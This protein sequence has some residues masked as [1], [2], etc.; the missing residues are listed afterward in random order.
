MQF[1]DQRLLFSL[2]LS[3]SQVGHWVL[4]ELEQEHVLMAH[5]QNAFQLAWLNKHHLLFHTQLVCTA[6]LL[7]SKRDMTPCM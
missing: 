6:L 5:L 7:H 4:P 1:S 2:Y 3:F